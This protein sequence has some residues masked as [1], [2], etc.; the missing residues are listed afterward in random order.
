MMNERIK[1][2]LYNQTYKEIDLSD[3][4]V[5]EEEL[6]SNRDDIVEVELPA[7]VKVIGPHAFEHCSRLERVVLPDTIER[8]ERDAFHNCRMLE[9]VVNMDKAVIAD[10]AFKGCI[11]L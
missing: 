6:F 9:E 4:T 11:N 8:I 5:I 3:F 10:G 2:K 7:G 1:I